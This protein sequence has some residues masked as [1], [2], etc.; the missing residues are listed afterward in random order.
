M[1]H[2]LAATVAMVVGLSGGRAMAGEEPKS[3]EPVKLADHE[4]D[5][6]TAGAGSL[7]PLNFNA[8]VLLQDITVNVNLSNV[9]INAGI[10]LQANVLGQA[11]Q[12][13]TVIA[14]Q[15]VTQA[16]TLPLAR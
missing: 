8:N 9:P 4:L 14:G 6:V 13:A 11:I 1:K 5:L 7:L 15:Q 2:V 16:Q 12:N 10:A 3:S